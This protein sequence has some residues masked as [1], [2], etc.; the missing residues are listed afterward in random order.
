MNCRLLSRARLMGDICFSATEGINGG[1][2]AF[3]AEWAARATDAQPAERNSDARPN[4]G[5]PRTDLAIGLIGARAGLCYRLGN[6]YIPGRVEEALP[7]RACGLL[8]TSRIFPRARFGAHI[9]FSATA[10][11]SG[12]EL[13]F[14]VEWEARATETHPAARNSES[15]THSVESRAR[16][17]VVLIGPRA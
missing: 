17:A 7:T 8:W 1:E 14:G 2:L 5:E 6:L 13:A 10:V 12:V 3:G 11:D 9:C 16:R 15:L 4:S